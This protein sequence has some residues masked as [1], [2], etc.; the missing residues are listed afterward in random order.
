MVS[1]TIKKERS[2]ELCI[3]DVLGRVIWQIERNYRP[4]KYQLRLP[5]LPAGI[6]FLK[7]NLS[8]NGDVK[9]ITV[10]K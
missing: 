5:E 10:I 6:Y 8:D 2:V 4:G 1:L 9:K 7:S 3:Y